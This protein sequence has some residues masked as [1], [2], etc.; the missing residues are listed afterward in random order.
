MATALSAVRRGR[1]RA[2]GRGLVRRGPALGHDLFADSQLALHD[3]A[4]GATPPGRDD[5][6]GR[7]GHAGPRQVLLAVHQRSP[8]R[9][10]CRRR[11]ARGRS[12]PRDGAVYRRRAAVVAVEGGRRRG[13]GA[14]VRDD[15]GLP[16][17]RGV[18]EEVGQLL[19]CHG[20]G[21]QKSSR[22][23]NH[24]VSNIGGGICYFWGRRPQEC[25]QFFWGK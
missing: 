15:E 2:L 18:E 24:R 13:R 23:F 9:R 7:Q 17:D 1:G 22:P 12:P 25:A 21:Q 5:P 3:H 14:A 20:D 4:R 11:G 6:P 19:V 8:R 16:R 10:R